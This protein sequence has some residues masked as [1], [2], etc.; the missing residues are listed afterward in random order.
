MIDKHDFITPSIKEDIMKLKLIDYRDDCNKWALDFPNP[1]PDAKPKRIRKVIPFTKSQEKEAYRHAIKIY[2]ELALE[3]DTQDLFARKTFNQLADEWF[4]YLPP[5]DDTIS[6]I[7][8][9]AEYIGD[10]DLRNIVRADYNKMI[11]GWRE[12]GNCNNT[13]NRKFNTL[14]SI[15]NFAIRNEYIK[16]FPNIIF[17]P[18]TK[19]KVS[20]RMSH[21]EI[22]MFVEE[23]TGNYSFLRDPFLFGRWTGLRKE[24]IQRLTKAH[25]FTTYQG[26]KEI[27]F[28][29]HEMKARRDFALPITRPMQEILD[30]NWHNDTDFIFK[31]Y[32]GK[33]Q[34]GDFKKSFNKIRE[35]VGI[36]NPKKGTLVEWR[37]LRGTRAS[38]LAERGIDVYS[39]MKIMDW[40]T[41]Q[42]ALNYIEAF[43]PKLH[44]TLS[45]I[46]EQIVTENVT[47][48]K[49]CIQERVSY[50]CD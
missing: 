50:N 43:A 6:K 44:E 17:L 40:K 26:T 34:L 30:R 21:S 22:Q 33:P 19:E 36:I 45:T 48:K 16:S 29:P 42:T 2:S 15:L 46:D 25:I 1:I 38:E 4:N 20:Y 35:R 47:A 41:L 11:E 37:D 9:I 13:I 3:R 8:L 24:N 5:T 49:D 23:M 31:G 32:G 12:K 18:V 27:R 10:K 28:R 39:L 14:S 7:N